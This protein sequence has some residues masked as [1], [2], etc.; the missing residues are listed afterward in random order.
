MFKNYF[1]VIMNINEGSIRL[2]KYCYIW[3]IPHKHAKILMTEEWKHCNFSSETIMM[4]LM[5]RSSKKLLK[6]TTKLMAS[7]FVGSE[8]NI[9]KSCFHNGNVVFHWPYMY[10]S[11]DQLGLIWYSIFISAHGLFNSNLLCKNK[12]LCFRY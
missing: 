7:P 8:D 1:F 4:K 9:K 5:W 11:W 12:K 6:K 2:I 3:Y 10:K